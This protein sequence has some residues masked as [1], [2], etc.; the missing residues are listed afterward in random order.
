MQIQQPFSSNKVRKFMAELFPADLAVER[1]KAQRFASFSQTGEVELQ[2]GAPAAGPSVP[3]T[4]ETFSGRRLKD[5][6]RQVTGSGPLTKEITLLS[7]KIDG[8]PK[9]S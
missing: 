6:R 9:A 1:E 7:A 5:K 2:S 4:V 8:C 3:K